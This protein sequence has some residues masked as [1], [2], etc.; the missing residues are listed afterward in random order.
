MPV[1]IPFAGTIASSNHQI[2]KPIH[3]RSASRSSACECGDE[4]PRYG[5]GD[6]FKRGLYD[7]CGHDPCLPNH[8]LSKRST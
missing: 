3:P 8:P 5:A 1:G 7:V 4:E 6:P 2:P